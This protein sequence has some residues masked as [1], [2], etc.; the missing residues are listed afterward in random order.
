LWPQVPSRLATRGALAPRLR[1]HSPSAQDPPP[2]PLPLRGALVFDRAHAI[3]QFGHDIGRASKF[4]RDGDSHL[5]LLGHRAVAAKE[6][7]RPCRMKRPTAHQSAEPIDTG[8][9]VHAID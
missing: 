8:P 9:V 7:K 6:V 5:K 2:R 4:R 3:P 1:E